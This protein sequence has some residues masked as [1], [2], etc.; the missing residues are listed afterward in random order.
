M[1]KPSDSCEETPRGGGYNGAPL[2]VEFSKR[3]TGSV[4]TVS[5][6]ATG[7]VSRDWDTY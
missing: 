1:I 6:L 2:S 5:A 7:A 3:L 4:P